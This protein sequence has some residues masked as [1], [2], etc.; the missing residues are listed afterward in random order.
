[1]AADLSKPAPGASPPGTRSLSRADAE[2]GRTARLCGVQI[3]GALANSGVLDLGGE[4]PV[5]R[6]VAE[7]RT[8]ARDENENENGVDA[9]HSP[10]PISPGF[11]VTGWTS[12]FLCLGATT[13]LMEAGSTSGR[14]LHAA[15]ASLLGLA[16]AQRRAAL[17]PELPA[18]LRRRRGG[19]GRRRRRGFRTGIRD[20]G[21]ALVRDAPPTSPRSVRPRPPRRVRHR[22]GTPRA[23]ATP[24]GSRIPRTAP[25][26]RSSTS[27]SPGCTASRAS[28]RCVRWRWSPPPTRRA[29]QRSPSAL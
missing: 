19:G 4:A 25:S 1:M 18:R 26:W 13:C 23:A 24:S 12:E 14:P 6:Y 11:A 20:G 2:Y 17:A 29:A 5:I 15:A 21:A 8:S 3:V 28:W 22:G 7:T 9:K 27:S 16:L 10:K